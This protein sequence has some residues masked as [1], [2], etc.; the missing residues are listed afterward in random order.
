MSIAS[1]IREKWILAR[2]ARRD[3]VSI[4]MMTVLHSDVQKI[5]KENN[6]EATNEEA[7]TVIRRLL[8]SNAEMQGNLP[9]GD[10]LNDV[11]HEQEIL[12]FFLPEQLTET[13]LNLIIG[14]I[15]I[16]VEATSVKDMGRVMQLLKERHGMAV[17]MGIASAIAKRLLG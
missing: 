3:F 8:K 7:V 14:Q 13:D 16:E 15:C 10:K 5:G 4:N 1:T 12:E 11:K 6:R 17:N 9:E 2:K